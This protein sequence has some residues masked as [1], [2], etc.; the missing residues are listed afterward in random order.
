MLRPTNRITYEVTAADMETIISDMQFFYDNGIDGY[1]FGAL[2]RDNLHHTSHRAIDIE[3]CMAVIRNSHNLPVTFHRAID[4]TDSAKLCDNLDAIERCGFKRV[5]SSGFAETAEKGIDNLIR[6]QQFADSRC[7]IMPGCGIT[8]NNAD[9][10][11]RRIQWREFHASARI[12]KV[13]DIIDSCDGVYQR[14]CLRNNP[15]YVTSEEIV[16]ELVESGKRWDIR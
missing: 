8:V 12:K 16:R 7:T 10:I 15:F 11:L 2:K 5:L 9:E 3:R 6:M 14:E 4:M 13:C 1:V